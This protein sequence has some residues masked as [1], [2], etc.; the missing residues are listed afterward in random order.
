MIYKFIEKIWR[1][2]KNTYLCNP[3]SK[4]LGSYNG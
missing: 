2:K 1:D 3:K 4:M